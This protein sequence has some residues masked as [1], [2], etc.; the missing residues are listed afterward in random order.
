M[1]FAKQANGKAEENGQKPKEVKV[2][3]KAPPIPAAVP[4]AVK[5]S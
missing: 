1:K 5:A 3:L 2:E 4:M